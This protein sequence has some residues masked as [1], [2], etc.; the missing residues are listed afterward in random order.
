LKVI[1]IK[2]PSTGKFWATNGDDKMYARIILRSAS[3]GGGDVGVRGLESASAKAAWL[4][5]CGL[6]D[7]T[8]Q[9]WEAVQRR[10]SLSQGR[11]LGT[12][13]LYNFGW[14]RSE[15]YEPWKQ[16]AGDIEVVQF[17][18]VENPAFPMKEYE[19][20][21]A[22]LPE[23]KFNMMYRGIF[24]RPAGQIYVDFDEKRHVEDPITPKTGARVVVGVDP[25][26][27]HTATVWLALLSDNR[28]HVYYE[29]LEGGMT[30]QGHTTRAKA[31]AEGLHDVTYY[32]GAASEKQ[33]RMDWQ[34]AGVPVMEPTISDVE[35]GIDRVIA[36]LKTDRLRISRMCSGIIDELTEYSRELDKSGQPTDKIKDKEKYH[37]L[38]ALRYAMSG[39]SGHGGSFFV[40]SSN[41]KW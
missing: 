15:I 19:R 35:A 13:T 29:T 41:R 9:A 33:F 40:S 8:L 12:T 16:G 11:V 7:F 26:A 31:K 24:D 22:S 28:W 1:E 3:A 39:V 20:M 32:G 30:T 23:W 27:V 17:D 36:L 18:S 25:G 10:L 21:R 2:D 34:N 4:D 5:E 37:R 14:L 6:D 38:D